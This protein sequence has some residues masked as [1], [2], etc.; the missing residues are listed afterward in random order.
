MRLPQKLESLSQE[1]R[2]LL[3]EFYN[4]YSTKQWF[5][6]AEI[7]ENHPR[8]FKKTLELTVNYPPLLEMKDI[9]SFVQK[10]SIAVETVVPSNNA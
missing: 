3:G 9:L 7:I 8:Q 1:D 5:D 4:L 2:T 6:R 10:Y